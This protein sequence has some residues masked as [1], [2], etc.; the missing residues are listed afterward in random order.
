DHVE[1]DDVGNAVGIMG[2]GAH[3]RLLIDGHVDSIPLHSPEHWTVDPFGGAIVDGRLY[4]LGICDQKG[5]I[6]AAAHG[7]ASARAALGGEFGGT[8][9]V[10]AS[11]SEE[12]VEGAA[13]A[14]ACER[15]DPDFAVTSE[16]SDT[17]L[18]TGQRGRA[19][20]EVVV[21]G[22]ACHA[23][24]RAQGINAAE[25]LA[26][27]VG[28]V[29]R[30]EHPVHPQLGRRDITCID[31]AS[32]P[33]PSVS[34]VPGQATARFDCRFVPGESEDSLLGAIRGCAER[35]LRGWGEA[36]RVEIRLVRAQFRTW[37][38]RECSHLEFEPAWWTEERSV[39][40]RRAMAGLESVGIDSTPTHYAFCTNGSYLAGVRGVPTVG[41]GVGLEHMAHQVDEFVT[42]SSLRTGA[43][44]FAALCAQLVA[45][46]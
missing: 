31:L 9:A 25:A 8:A 3:P 36:P 19:K 39:L 32:L 13:L 17:R 30:L 22:R 24:H 38:G 28:E 41:F 16:P 29:A 6:A 37:R 23:G 42:L 2:S 44:G 40:V 12:E 21:E 33:Y 11:V 35:A 34:T 45:V 15:F 20:V 43:R 46:P 14:S 5:S 7:V 4:G 18:C 10:V 26:A 1:I 27:I